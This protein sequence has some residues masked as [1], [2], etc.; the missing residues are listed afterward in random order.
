MNAFNPAAYLQRWKMWRPVR[1]LAFQRDRHRL[2]HLLR[3]G[4]H[5]IGHFLKVNQPRSYNESMR[6][7]QLKHAHIRIFRLVQRFRNIPLNQADHQLIRQHIH[8]LTKVTNDVFVN[9]MDVTMLKNDL[10]WVMAEY[11]QRNSTN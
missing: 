6:H 2:V 4:N 7:D 10:V 1:Y 9:D 8:F 5:I 3:E 11:C